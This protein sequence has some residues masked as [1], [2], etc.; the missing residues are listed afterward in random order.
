MKTTKRGV[1]L[2]DSEGLVDGLARLG[3]GISDA[4]ADVL[5]STIAKTPPHLFFNK[6]GLQKKKK[7]L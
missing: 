2:V 7:T 4:A 3:V 5:T 1:G 6:Q